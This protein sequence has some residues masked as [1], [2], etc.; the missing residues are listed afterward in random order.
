LPG[1]GRGLFRP[2]E[3]G[4]GLRRDSPG[5]ALEERLRLAGQPG[6]GCALGPGLQEVTGLRGG[7]PSSPRPLVRAATP[8]GTSPGGLRLPWGGYRRGFSGENRC[9]RSFAWV[10]SLSGVAAETPGGVHLGKISL[11]I[12][13]CNLETLRLLSSCCTGKS[14]R[15]RAKEDRIMALY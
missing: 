13:F 4:S 8:V 10:S 3:G 14:L 5:Q 12:A 9:N 6:F 1:R 11:I 2:A 7:A 15:P